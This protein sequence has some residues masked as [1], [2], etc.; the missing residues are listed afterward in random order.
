MTPNTSVITGDI[1]GV[2]VC[3]RVFRDET[4]PEERYIGCLRILNEP[5]TITTSAASQTAVLCQL[6]DD[7]RVL[8]ELR[9]LPK[10]GQ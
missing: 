3:G 2:P 4:S 7:A 6:E 1:D 10:L 9:N 5:N 8:I